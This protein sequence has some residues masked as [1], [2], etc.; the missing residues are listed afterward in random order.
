MA[1]TFYE[2][3]DLKLSYIKF[4]GVLKINKVN[5]KAKENI[6]KILNSINIKLNINNPFNLANNELQKLPISIDF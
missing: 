1:L 3:G 4:I 5:K 2:S 6:I